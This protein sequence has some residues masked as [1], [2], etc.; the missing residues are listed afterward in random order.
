M[1]VAG[2]ASGDSHSA[3]LVRELRNSAGD[4]EFFGCAG[5]KMREAG[6]EAIVNADGLSVVGLPEIAR[7]L[8]TFIR[9]FRRLKS[10]AI[11]RRPDVVL[12]LPWNLEPELTK[13]LAYIA[14]WGG[15]LVFPLPTLHT[16]IGESARQ[17]E[18]AR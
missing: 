8:P 15:E 4:V 12:A 1:I 11:A 17:Q 3:K 10:A 16:A 6:V 9:A 13:Q 18:V 5:P 14:E 2:E 7:A